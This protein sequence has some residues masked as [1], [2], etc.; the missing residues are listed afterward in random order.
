MEET[1]QPMNERQRTVTPEEGAKMAV[2]LRE[3]LDNKI[4][5]LLAMIGVSKLISTPGGITPLIL[6]L[7]YGIEHVLLAAPHQDVREVVR[8]KMLEAI[9]KGMTAPLDPTVTMPEA[10]LKHV[11]RRES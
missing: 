6:T 10:M 8:A 5:D 3:N 11:G 4:Y 1:K 7:A 2:D 9:D